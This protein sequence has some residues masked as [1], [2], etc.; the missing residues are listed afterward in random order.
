MGMTLVN[1]ASVNVARLSPEE[2]ETLTVDHCIVPLYCSTIKGILYLNFL[3]SY[4]MPP[5]K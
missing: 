3:A 4:N 5:Y 1:H 2:G